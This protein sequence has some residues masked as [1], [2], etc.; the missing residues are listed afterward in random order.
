[1]PSGKPHPPEIRRAVVAELLA[2]K[3]LNETCKKY[4]VAKAS[5]KLWKAENS[6]VAPETA[7]TREAMAILIYDTL[8]EVL[9][10]IRVQLR[11]ASREEWLKEQTAGD[12]AALLGTEFDRAIRL[13]AGF[14]P[15]EPDDEPRVLPPGSDVP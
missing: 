14:R 3:G 11:A 13:L 2:G 6:P 8:T 1:M 7:R 5:A 4:G 15:A 12:V 10:A 9:S